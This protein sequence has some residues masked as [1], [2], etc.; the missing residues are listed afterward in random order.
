MGRPVECKVFMV[1]VNGD[2]VRGRQEDMSPGMKFMNDCK[3][4]SVMDVIVSFH[5]VEG[6]RYTSDGSESSSIIFL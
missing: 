1:S 6:T 4:F 5:L 3:Q 2:N